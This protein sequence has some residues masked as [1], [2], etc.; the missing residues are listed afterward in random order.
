MTVADRA[1]TVVTHDSGN[2]RD[3]VVPFYEALTP[4][5]YLGWGKST[6][7]GSGLGLAMGAKLARPDWLSVNFMGD[8]SFGMVGLDVE[9]GVRAGIPV[10]TIVFNNGVMGGYTRHHPVATRTHGINRQ[11][12]RYAEVALAMGAAGERVE[13]VADL[14][15][16]MRRCIAATEGGRS[17]L[18]EVVTREEPQFPHIRTYG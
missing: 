17:A 3:Q 18:L 9:T 6:P 4:L 8:S 10:L 12:G 5:G 7:L 1:R 14:E 2:P 15:P 13:R 16:A 11:G